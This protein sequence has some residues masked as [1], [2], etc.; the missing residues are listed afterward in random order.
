MDEAVKLGDTI[1]VMRDGKVAQIGTP[2]ELLLRPENAFVADLLGQDRLIKLLQTIPVTRMLQ[3]VS[4]EVA[5]HG[6][7]LSLRATM[8]DAFL[9][10]LAGDTG[11]LYVIDESSAVIGRLERE[12]C[13]SC[14]RAI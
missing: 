4:G 9:A 1:V 11:P 12:A 14:A 13:F 3:P 5:P 8:H 2:A 10:F 7:P 6:Q